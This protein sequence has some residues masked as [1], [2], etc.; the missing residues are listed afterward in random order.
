MMDLIFPIIIMAMVFAL[1]LGI[2]YM[3]LETVMKAMARG[4]NKTPQHVHVPVIRRPANPRRPHA[5]FHIAEVIKT[6][7]QALASH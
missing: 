5:R 7:L 6:R 2:S 3:C 4:L 1:A